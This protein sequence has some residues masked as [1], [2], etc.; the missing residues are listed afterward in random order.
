MQIMLE[1]H[2]GPQQSSGSL[3]KVAPL[4]PTAEGG[5][6]GASSPGALSTLLA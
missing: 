1:R 2:T 3:S 4:P 5:S 6:P